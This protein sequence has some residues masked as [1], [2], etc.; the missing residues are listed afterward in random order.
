MTLE[1]ARKRY[2]IAWNRLFEL[3]KQRNDLLRQLGRIVQYAGDFTLATGMFIE[4][5]LDQAQDILAR[6][7]K[8]TPQIYE[9]IADVNDYA[10]LIGKSGI[11]RRKG[12]PL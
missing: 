5:D 1:Q 10:E 9:A 7:Q 2:D 4:F 11:T 3:V 8:L 12:L 6:V